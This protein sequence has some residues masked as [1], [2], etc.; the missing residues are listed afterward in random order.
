MLDDCTNDAV[1]AV[2][3]SGKACELL[4]P[5]LVALHA[6]IGRPQAASQ[7]ICEATRNP[8]YSVEYRRLLVPLVGSE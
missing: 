7:A 3:R 2:E 5:L 4:A 8:E 6:K 1:A